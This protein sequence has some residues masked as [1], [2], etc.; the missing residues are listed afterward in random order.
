MAKDKEYVRGSMDIREQKAMF[1]TFW[2]VTQVSLGGLAL[3]LI[4]LAMFRTGG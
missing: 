3:L 1:E 2:L 4:F